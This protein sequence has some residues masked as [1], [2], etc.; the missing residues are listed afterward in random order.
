MQ[1]LNDDF[2]YYEKRITYKSAW[3]CVEKAFGF[4]TTCCKY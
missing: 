4:R 1:F 3:S 2:M